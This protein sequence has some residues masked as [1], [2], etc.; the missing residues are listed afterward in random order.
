MEEE[1]HHEEYWIAESI[2][3]TKFEDLYTLGTEL[4]RGTS[5]VVYRCEHNGTKKAYAVKK[6]PKQ[7]DRKVVQAEV[8]IF[9]HIRHP[10]VIHITELYETKTHIYLMMELVTGGELFDRIVARGSF[11]EKD[12]AE[13]MRDILRALKCMHDNGV[14]HY[15]VKPEN[16]LY[17]SN[18]DHSKLKLADFAL[19][20]IIAGD[21]RSN[22][23]CE[24]PGYVPPEVLTGISYNKP[25][26]VDMWSCGVIAYIL[27]CG[28]E[29]FE[30]P[31]HDVSEIYKKIL[32]V[33]YKFDPAIWSKISENAKDFIKR[34]LQKDPR[35]RLSVDVALRHPWVTGIAAKGD[36]LIET[37][38]K[39]REF[40]ARRKLKA[41]AGGVLFA[42]RAVRM[43]NMKPKV[44]IQL[45]S[46]QIATD[47]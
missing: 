1:T 12:A 35:K 4:G 16:L 42:A 7:K 31:T 25:T 45:E 23:V 46:S 6:I 41:A 44:K 11:S 24:S 36:H 29:P 9:L 43:M 38:E 37:Q 26:A 5:A 32:K 34:L 8:G 10:N 17:E 22:S 30:S 33:D 15:D 40:N 19:S 13:A 2:R 3:D 21:V 47:A 27:L 28:Y 14:V 39:I 18:K 20:H